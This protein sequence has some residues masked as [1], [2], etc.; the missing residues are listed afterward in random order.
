MRHFPLLPS[1]ALI[2]GLAAPAAFAAPFT[3][4]LTGVVTEANGM[5]ADIALGSTVEVDFTIDATQA[6]S[7]SFQ[8]TSASLTGSSA[9]FMN[10]QVFVNGIDI[11]LNRNTLPDLS[12]YESVQSQI[13]NFFPGENFSDFSLEQNFAW[14]GNNYQVYYS[15]DA[16]DESAYRADGTVPAFSPS[17]QSNGAVNT[18]G[19]FIGYQVTGSRTFAGFPG[20][21]AVPAPLSA[22]LLG[23][24]LLG[25]CLRRRSPK[26][27]ASGLSS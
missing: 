17:A 6:S 20:A 13:F 23:L 16:Q 18:N 14:D 11:T 24:G 25:A 26:A 7:S 22:G 8:S 2:L 3:T 5:Y 21:A 9:G 27:A 12:V 1:I 15:T 19:D 4:E 10:T